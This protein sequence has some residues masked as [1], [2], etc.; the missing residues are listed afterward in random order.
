MPFDEKLAQRIR[1]LLDGNHAFEEKRM[2]G[3]LAFMVNGHMC[4]GIVGSDLMVRVGPDAYE[5]V[6]KQPGARAM[7]F[8]G[9][10]MRGFVYVEAEACRTPGELGA[11][12]QR[13]V[14]FAHS[15]APK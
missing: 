11:W 6:L 7:D 12:V 10:P 5:R 13:G 3:G 1:R 15:L 2:F 14:D 8:T 4:C 9:K